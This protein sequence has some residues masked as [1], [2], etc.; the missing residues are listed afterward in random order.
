MRAALR[1]PDAA[2]HATHHPERRL[3]MAPSLTEP[4]AARA[5][6]PLPAGPS[7]ATTG[8]P[9]RAPRAAVALS[10]RSLRPAILA[11]VRAAPG[12]TMSEVA[13]RA[14]ASFTVTSYH[15]RELAR[16][17]AV[18][19][20]RRPGPR[21]YTHAFVP[22]H[23][24]A[25]EV[26]AAALALDARAARA[27]RDA[28]LAHALPVGAVALAEFVGLSVPAVRFHLA[29]LEA[30]GVV[31]AHRDRRRVAWRLAGEFGA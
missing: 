29:R 18:V 8:L 12:L 9:P 24:P 7:P 19:L 5:R 16:E 17:R 15:L 11:L 10:E 13:R 22:E 25:R 14:G 1:S 26:R 20:V 2:Q 23:A 27:I 30:A 4:A 21:T 6:E 31:V 3:G 28:L